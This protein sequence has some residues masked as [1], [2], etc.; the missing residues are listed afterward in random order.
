MPLPLP[1]SASP[2]APAGDNGAALPR[3]LVRREGHPMATAVSV[4]IAV[5][6][7]HVAAAEAAA[8]ACMG[9]FEEVDHRL[10]RFRPESELSRLNAAAGR[11]SA[12]SEV[13]YE[14]V[15]VAVAAA[16][17]S[18]GL[19]DPTMLGELEALGYDRDFT[20]IAQRESC[21][22]QEK[23]H[24]ALAPAISRGLQAA[25]PTASMQQ[26]ALSPRPAPVITTPA[27]R[28]AWRAIAFDSKRRRIKLP[29][30]ARVDLGGIAKGWAAD[31]ALA[32]FCASFPGA[33]I[34]V[35]GD[36]RAQGGPAAGEAWSVGIRHPAVELA[37]PPCARAPREAYAGVLHFS[38]GGLATSG[39]LRRWWLRDGQR[40]HHLLDPRTGRPIPLWI[41]DRD[42]PGQERVSAASRLATATALAPTAAQAEV[43]AKVAL[44]RGYPQ[45][46]RAVE[47]AWARYGA[48]GPAADADAGVALALVFGDGTVA[49]SQ[50]LAAYLATLG[51]HGAS[52]PLNVHPSLTR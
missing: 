18:G 42:A 40:Q 50:N 1:P 8:D 52:L 46:L 47:A 2:R 37:G 45:A 49:L 31:V 15:S 10:S 22:L 7:D 23:P 44:L 13:L 29:R 51:T 39:A 41:D 4:Q 38:R 25:D 20:R 27:R 14:A 19:F 3:T 28:A 21:Q 48:V 43:A 17:A 34:N 30:G 16:A 6:P 35:G 32:R 33:L 26:D 5:H 11:W 12:A 9:W 24:S 36:L